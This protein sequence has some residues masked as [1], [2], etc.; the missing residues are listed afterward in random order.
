MISKH[1]LKVLGL[2]AIPFSYLLDGEEFH[3][4]ADFHNATCMEDIT[5]CRRKL[6]GNNVVFAGDNCPMANPETVEMYFHKGFDCAVYV[7]AVEEK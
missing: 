6:D 3:V 2:K 1:L 4:D 7:P 5:I